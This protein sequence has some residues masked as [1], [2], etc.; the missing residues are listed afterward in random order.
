MNNKE[1]FN[2]V[3]YYVRAT[4]YE[5]KCKDKEE[6]K[7]IIREV[8]SEN[9]DLSVVKMGILCKRRCLSEL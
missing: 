5:S 7:M 1:F 9:D 8:I 4:W 6:I 3:Y 2:H